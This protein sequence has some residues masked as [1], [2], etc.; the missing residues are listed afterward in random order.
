M[1]LQQ[2]GVLINRAEVTKFGLR[3]GEVTIVFRKLPAAAAAFSA[4]ARHNSATL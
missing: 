3:L 4:S 1:F 2:D